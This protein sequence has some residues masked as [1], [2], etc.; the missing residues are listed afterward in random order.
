MIAV[1]DSSGVVRLLHRNGTEKSRLTV[2]GAVEAM[3]RNGATLAISAAGEGVQL[4]DMS[5]PKQPPTRCLAGAAADEVAEA[6][7]SAASS[8]TWDVHLSQLLYVGMTNGDMHVYNTKARTRQPTGENARAS[9]LAT[10]DP[11]EP[12]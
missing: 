4:F 6:T 12:P 3:E 10:H 1:G 2:G 11:G 5:K 7:A 8:M 9:R